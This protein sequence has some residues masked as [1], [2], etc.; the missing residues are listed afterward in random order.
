LEDVLNINHPPKYEDCA[1][2]QLIILPYLQFTPEKEM[3]A[4][5][6]VIIQNNNTVITLRDA[7]D[8]IYAPVVRRMQQLNLRISELGHHYTFY[9][10]LDLH[11]DQY[12]VLSYDLNDE[13]LDL[14]EAIS[15]N[16]EKQHLRRIKDLRKSLFFFK[17]N[18]FPL[19]DMVRS[20]RKN[21]NFSDSGDLSMYFDDLETHLNDVIENINLQMELIS[22]LFDIYTSSLGIRANEVMKTL[23]IV[24]T[25]FIPLTFIVGIYG[26]N[27]KHMPELEMP[28]G[29]YAVMLFML[30]CALGMLFLMKRK[31][32]L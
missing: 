2:F 9:A 27:F 7:A 15:E 22:N 18:V 21:Q 29:Y 8:D 13:I 12:H 26:M 14:E 16:P 10:L 31:K 30:I 24:G 1:I 6:C 23:T 20:M 4:F 19:R 25:I 32:W 17:K 5:Q 11:V 3:Q 28:Y